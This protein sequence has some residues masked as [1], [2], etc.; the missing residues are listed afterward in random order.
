LSGR[1]ELLRRWTW[2]WW[3]AGIVTDLAILVLFGLFE[4]RRDDAKALV[5]K[6]KSWE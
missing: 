4:K 1:I 5:E 3:I 2:I 6:L